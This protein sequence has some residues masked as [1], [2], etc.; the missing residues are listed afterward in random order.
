MEGKGIGSALIRR[1]EDVV[2]AQVPVR[3]GLPHVAWARVLNRPETRRFYADRVRWQYMDGLRGELTEP[4]D[5][6]DGTT[7]PT[8]K[9]YKVLAI[10]R[11]E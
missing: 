9:M 8:V 5:D 10:P 11:A 6:K 2:A 4:Y 3:P 1:Y 7:E